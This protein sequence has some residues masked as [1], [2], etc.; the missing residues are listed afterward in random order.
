MVS[1]A[2]RITLREHKGLVSNPPQRVKLGDIPRVFVKKRRQVPRM[3]F[4]A[5]PGV[6]TSRV[7]HMA[8][9]IWRIHVFPVPA[10]GEPHAKLKTTVTRSIGKT[11]GRGNTELVRTG[12]TDKLDSSMFEF[13]LVEAPTP[14]ISGHHA[15]S[16][17]E[18]LDLVARAVLCP[19]YS[20]PAAEMA[21]LA[22]MCLSHSLVS[23]APKELTDSTH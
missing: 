15:E 20:F 5:A 9:V 6:E 17:R 18:W 13:G 14:V 12:E 2:S 8:L 10:R 4:R 19:V 1:I 21:R 23:Y 3:S 7:C 11:V 22:Y 16:G